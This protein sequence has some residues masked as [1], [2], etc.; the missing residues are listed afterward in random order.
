MFGCGEEA[1]DHNHH[2]HDHSHDGHDHDAPERGLEFSLFKHVDVPKILCLNE[3][4]DGQAKSVIKPWAERLDRTKFLESDVD[5]QLLV[6]I[7]FTGQ[8]KLKSILLRGAETDHAPCKLKVWI[9][10]NDLDFEM[11]ES[12]EPVQEWDLVE[13]PPH[14][15]VIEYQTRMTKF[16]QVRNITLFFPNNFG[17]HD[18]TRIDYIGFKGE[19]QELH[20]DPVVTIY[21]SAPRPADHPK[22]EAEL[23]GSRTIQ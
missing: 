11:A 1:H 10:R 7:P 2:G 22:T 19:W 17:E 6:Y 18:V 3:A 14:D 12:M 16:N 15:D 8:V 9:N 4:V 20:L 5:E 23:W 13:D 21:E